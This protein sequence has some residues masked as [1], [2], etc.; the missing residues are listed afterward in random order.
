MY[1]RVSP[2][3][4][5]QVAHFMVLEWYLRNQQDKPAWIGSENKIHGIM[6]KNQAWCKYVKGCIGMVRTCHIINVN[7]DSTEVNLWS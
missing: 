2:C 3:V 5:F 7:V 6:S 4:L 1:A